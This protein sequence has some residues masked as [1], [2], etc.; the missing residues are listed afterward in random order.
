MAIDYA[1]LKT[2]LTTD[3]EALGYPG[4]NEDQ[5]AALINAVGSATV[6]VERASVTSQEILAEVRQ[7]EWHAIGEDQAGEYA[8]E[9]ASRQRLFSVLMTVGGQG[10]EGLDWSDDSVRN[11]IRSCFPATIASNTRTAIIALE[12]IPDTVATRA[13]ELFGHGVSVSP[14]DIAIADNI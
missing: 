13:E 14:A 9:G 11:L 5:R 7:A 4:Q 8:G 12:T 6:A 10:V 1:A 3:P 2:E